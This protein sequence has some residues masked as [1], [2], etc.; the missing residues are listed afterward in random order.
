MRTDRGSAAPRVL[1]LNPP[2]GRAVLRDHY[3]ASEA[4]SAYLWQPLDL[5]VQAAVLREAGIDHLAIDAVAEGLDHDAVRRR[6]TAY[7]PTAAVVLVSCRTWRSDRR[8][9][10]D[11]RGAGVRTVVASGDFVRF[12]TD[13]CREAQD[14]GLVD[15]SL[16]DFTTTGLPAAL[17]EGPTSR[18]GLA[19]LDD[20]LAG[21]FHE[22]DDPE[23]DYPTLDPE[24]F[25]P[26]RYRLPYPGFRRIASVLATYG[27]PYPCRFCHV[28]Q[29]GVRHR[30]PAE[31]L[32]D[33]A[34]ARAAGIRRIYVRDATANADPRH[35]AAWT[36]A[37]SS[38][39]LALPWA[40]FVTARPFDDRLASSMARAGCVHLQVGIETLADALRKANGK[41]SST[42]DFRRF[43][44][45]CRR[46]GIHS[47]A[48][49]VLG[50]AGETT[51]TLAE[52]TEG[53]ASIGFDYIA[54][55]LA[56]TRP[57][58]PWRREGVSLALDPLPGGVLDRGEG[59]GLEELV[60]AQRT[61][62]R[63]SYLR[64]RRLLQELGRRIRSRDVGDLVGLARTA[65]GW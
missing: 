57:G 38:A 52:T 34:A 5:L 29:L 59:P 42:Q 30:P 31:I 63:T 37:V 41:A 7:G 10:S 8:T 9:L 49:V 61:L 11:L 65:A 40:T 14:A 36:D 62:Y 17:R 33:F 44:V 56:E 48:H 26:R 4:K 32:G 21:R 39:G 25:D 3:C 46:A 27:C 55:N 16:T 13:P 28:G 47:T 43:V 22:R 50:L 23:L 51:A 20:I 35:L 12:G 53:L 15:L 6:A 24:L 2:A 19:T 58:T 64:P 18:P 1:L 60:A 45:T 54:V